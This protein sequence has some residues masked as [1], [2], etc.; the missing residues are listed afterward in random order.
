M[1]RLILGFSLAF[2]LAGALGIAWERS[3]LLTWY[4]AYRLARANSA[5][6]SAWVERLIKLDQAAVPSL[7]R[8]LDREDPSACDNCR[9]ALLGLACRWE[10]GDSR[11]E[12]LFGQL[13]NAYADLSVSGQQSVLE[14]AREYL[15]SKK[16]DFAT[17]EPA[18]LSSA[19]QSC[20]DLARAALRDSRPENRIK[21]VQLSQLLGG[22][23]LEGVVPLLR[24]SDAE[25]RQAAILA[26]GPAPEAITD[27]DLLYSLHDPDPKVRQLCETAL[28]G[29]GLRDS[30]LKVGKLM[31]DRRPAVRLEVVDHLGRVNNLEPGALLRRLSHDQSSAVR[32]AAARA[33][34]EQP[35]AELGDRL[36]QMVQNDPSPTVQQLAQYYLSCLKRGNSH[37]PNA[38]K[39]SRLP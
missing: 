8:W 18:S 21:A 36:E 19:L 11:T 12:E 6:R 29:R 28:R 17:S 27:D 38:E 33:A 5:D 30:Q 7:I 3:R 14:F 34:A 20:Q 23:S 24:D 4:Y 25:V 32:A 31:T 39:K 1:K 22:N 9:L 2:V 26:V 13:R 37:N 35:V 16:A 15:D 10:S